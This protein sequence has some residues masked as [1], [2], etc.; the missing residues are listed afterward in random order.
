MREELRQH[1][2]SFALRGIAKASSKILLK[3]ENV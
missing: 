1:F 3:L 2:Y